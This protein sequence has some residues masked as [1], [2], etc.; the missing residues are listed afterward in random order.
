MRRETAKTVLEHVQQ[1]GLALSQALDEIKASCT[2]DEFVRHR[3]GF[4]VAYES[5]GA[6]LNTVHAEHPDL[7]TTR[8][9]VPYLP[10]P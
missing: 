4:A 1:S 10:K 5:L 8:V 7:D 3:D 6:I 2:A 9:T